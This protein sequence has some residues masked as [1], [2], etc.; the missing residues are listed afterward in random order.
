MHF[1][2]EVD[3]YLNVALTCGY[4][5]LRRYA[6]RACQNQSNYKIRSLFKLD[7]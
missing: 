2:L 7:G 4:V 6:I 1:N 3:I 5:I